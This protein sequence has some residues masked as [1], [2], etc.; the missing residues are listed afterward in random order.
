[1]Q[2]APFEFADGPAGMKVAS[3]GAVCV[4]LQDPNGRMFRRRGVVGLQTTPP[5]EKLLPKLNEFAG[6]LVAN[7]EM[8]SHEAVNKLLAIAG[9]VSTAE[10]QRKE[11]CVVELDGVRIYINGTEIIVTKRELTP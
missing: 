6:H 1:M 3:N 11:W 9:T 7:L 8:G 5:A 4:A 10:P 2:P